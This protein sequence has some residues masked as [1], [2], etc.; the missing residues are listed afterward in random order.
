VRARL[1][2][3]AIAASVISVIWSG[4]TGL[5]AIWL[6]RSTASTALLGYGA[7]AAIDAAASIALIWRFAIEHRDADRAD[8]V[9]ARAERILGLVLLGAGA[10]VGFAAASAL[11]GG[12]HAEHTPIGIALLVASLVILPPLAIAKRRLAAGL[13]SAALASDAFLTGASAILAGI[14]LAG[15]GAASL[16]VWW[17]DPL[18][19]LVIAAAMLREGRTVVR[20]SGQREPG[21]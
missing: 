17:A 6:S 12:V 13:S 16:G 3:R 9:E 4:L 11:A 8:A 10:V 1:L 5:I 18:G 19:A 20:R 15:V 21:T 2:R 14:G 7:E